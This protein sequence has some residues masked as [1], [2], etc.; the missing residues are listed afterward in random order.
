MS[1]WVN[2]FFI[3][4]EAGGP[5]ALVALALATLVSE[6][7]AC[8]AAGLL[9]ARG[10]LGF[11]EATAACFIGI[12]IGD[13]LLVALGRWLGRGA[14]ERWP[15]RG[16]V[17]AAALARAEAWFARSGARVVLASRFM[18]GTRL[19][20]FVA[21][22]VL[23]APWGRF[24]AWFALAC[25]LWTPLLVGAAWLAGEAVFGWLAAWSRAVP[26]LLVAAG[27]AWVA[28][29]AVGALATWRGRRLM[30]SRWQRL[31]RWEFWPMWAVYPP[32]VA[33][34]M[35]LG[36]RHRGMLLF[37]VVNPGLEAGGGLVGESK[38]G[39]LRGLAGAG[40]RIAAWAAVPAGSG[41]ERAAVVAVFQERQGR[42]W[43]VVLK[44]DVGERGSGVVIAR[45]EAEI[46]AKLAADAGAMIVQRY[47]PGVEFGVFYIRRPSEKCGRIFALTDKRTVVV[48]GDGRSTLERL[49]L[50]DARAVCMAAYFLEHYGERGRLGEVPEAGEEVVL[51]EL[52]THCRGALFL[53]G[54]HL[55][56]PE[57]EAAVEAVSRA[58][59]GFYFGRYDVRAESAEMLR[60]GEFIVI[61]LNGVSSEATS[62]YDPKHT[63]WHGW[64]TLC[65]QWKEAYGIAAENRARGARVLTAREVKS[66]VW[67]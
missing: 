34:I 15:L 57:L 43:P 44:P 27:A 40:E 48:K 55:V 1:G 37:T 21:A 2:Q 54:G 50:A 29:R 25:A 36:L 3:V 53:D 45:S 58:H 41:P 61:E 14:L 23:R 18:P 4:A 22:G 7:L 8:I 39:I 20:T 33:Y 46:A 11:G 42:R 35:W 63:V 5:W 67:R 56:T 13:L 64:R 30:W 65:A 12:F 10:A 38:S 51:A 6:D 28:V 62:I 9:V 47:V 31:T 26:A 49:I 59:A 24:A 17:S 66:L 60:R 19:P 52:G 32:V 16:R